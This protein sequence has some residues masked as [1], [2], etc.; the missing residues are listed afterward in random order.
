MIAL[1]IRNLGKQLVAEVWQSPR[2][3]PAGGLTLVMSAVFGILV[4]TTHTI[5]G[6]I[7]GASRRLTAVRWGV[8]RRILWAWVWTIPGSALIGTTIYHFVKISLLRSPSSASKLSPP[9]VSQ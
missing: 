9:F 2:N 1:F 5:T 6:A 8:T 7:V 4:S 3:Q